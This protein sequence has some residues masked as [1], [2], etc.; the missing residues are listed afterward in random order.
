MHITEA[1]FHSFVEKSSKA[2]GN[3]RVFP[4]FTI[5]LSND[6]IEQ[7]GKWGFLPGNGLSSPLTQ[8]VCMNPSSRAQAGSSRLKPGM[9]TPGLRELAERCGVQSWR[10]GLAVGRCHVSAPGESARLDD[11]GKSGCWRR[12]VKQE[13]VRGGSRRA[14]EMTRTKLQLGKHGVGVA[15]GR[16]TGRSRARGW[17]SQSGERHSFHNHH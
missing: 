6:N 12:A 2:T 13:G 4:K 8:Q 3:A 5:L 15:G 17:R 16:E 9:T 10:A 11:T 1:T 7:F 14:G